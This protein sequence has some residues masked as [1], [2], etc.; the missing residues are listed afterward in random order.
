MEM[1]AH[2]RRQFGLAHGAKTAR[3]LV[4]PQKPD[5]F[6]LFDET[7]ENADGCSLDAGEVREFPRHEVGDVVPDF[8]GDPFLSRNTERVAPQ[9]AS[10]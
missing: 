5:L 10:A 6:T 3:L 8:H 2:G 1:T 9:A 7:V 4:V